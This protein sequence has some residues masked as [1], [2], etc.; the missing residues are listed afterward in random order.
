MYA[1]KML[2]FIAWEDLDIIE[3]VE[4]AHGA[5]PC[6][7]RGGVIG[8]GGY[9]VESFEHVAGKVGCVGSRGDSQRNVM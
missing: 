9:Y 5:A 1:R 3:I 2:R 6:V 8:E 4:C 7:Q